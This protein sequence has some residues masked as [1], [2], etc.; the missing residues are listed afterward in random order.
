[1]N[2]PICNLNYYSLLSSNL[3][4]KAHYLYY[5]KPNKT[6]SYWDFCLFKIWLSYCIR[7]TGLQHVSKLG[8]KFLFFFTPNAE[9][10]EWLF[11]SFNAVAAW[12]RLVSNKILVNLP[13]WLH[14]LDINFICGHAATRGRRKTSKWTRSWTRNIFEMGKSQPPKHFKGDFLADCCELV[15]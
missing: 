11:R 1:M 15:G 8:E 3:M 9:R 12:P 13:L 7:K 5:V 14:P 10:G 4:Y 6:M 2:S